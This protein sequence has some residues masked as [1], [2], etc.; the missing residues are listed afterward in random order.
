[1]V[2]DLNGNGCIDDGSEMFGSA[3]VLPDGSRAS[4]GF[5]A[6]AALDQNGDGEI[7]A[8]DPAFAE[9][10]VWTDSNQNGVT[11]PGE[12]R[13]LSSVQID[14]LSLAATPARQV[15]QGNLVGLIGSYRSSD[16][17]SH[18]LADVWLAQG[19]PPSLNASVGQLAAALDQA[20]PAGAAQSAST[21]AMVER[22][23]AQAPFGCA[24]P[25]SATLAV[26]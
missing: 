6:L 13:S 15:Q 11:D 17:Q 9:L 24:W 26:R 1:L 23:R 3:T 7:S 10:G 22:D 2:R 14:A 18:L 8:P 12:L 20:L 25:W 21:W 4:N 19:A 16:G 5:M